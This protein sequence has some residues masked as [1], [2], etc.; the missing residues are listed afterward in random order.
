MT[1]FLKDV[2]MKVVEE[3]R[4]AKAFDENHVYFDLNDMWLKG[5]FYDG[6]IISYL[7]DCSTLSKSLHSH[8]VL[9]SVLY[10]IIR[11][12][13]GSKATTHNPMYPKFNNITLDRLKYPIADIDNIITE[14]SKFNV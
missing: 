11:F 4:Q 3:L 13:F 6:D 7:F 9:E 8:D 14:M 1:Y 5:G 12:N 2:D 10:N